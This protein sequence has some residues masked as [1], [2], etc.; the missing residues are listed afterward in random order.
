VQFRTARHLYH[1][2]P[3][4]G[5]EFEIAYKL[6]AFCTQYG[7]PEF[8][9]WVLGPVFARFDCTVASFDWW[10]RNAKHVL[11]PISYDLET[12][13]RLDPSKEWRLLVEQAARA[14]TQVADKWVLIR[15]PGLLD[16]S[17]Y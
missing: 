4:E 6:F 12:A 2:T 11:P 17:G 3:K 13:R 1:V 14:W 5:P 10:E 15:S 8:S 7:Y 9:I 16:S